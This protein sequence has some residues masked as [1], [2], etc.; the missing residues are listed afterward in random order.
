VAA[1]VAVSVVCSM[2]PQ[3]AAHAVTVAGVRSDTRWIMQSAD[4]DA[5]ATNPSKQEILPYEGNY[6]AWGLAM[7]ARVTGDLTRA[8][9][10][11]HWLYWF[12]SHMNPSFDYAV[13][14]Y[15]KQGDGT[16]AP[17]PAGNGTDPCDTDSTDGTAGVFMNAV[18]AAWLVD[19]QR[20]MPKLMGLHDAIAHA[21]ETIDATMS[22]NGLTQATPSWPVDYLMDNAE[23]Y[24]GLRAAAKLARALGDDAL[25]QHASYDAQKERHG[26]NTVLWNPANRSYDWAK[27]L[28]HN[29]ESVPCRWNVLYP[30]AVEEAWAVAYGVPPNRDTRQHL[31]DMFWNPGNHGDWKDPGAMDWYFDAAACPGTTCRQPV[32]YWPLVGIAF[33]RAGNTREAATGAQHIHDY[34]IGHGR[35]KPLSVGSAGMLVRLEL[36]TMP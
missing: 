10:A 1:A 11:W 24:G 2:L 27:H 32:G 21:V 19:R 31:M 3:T 9:V 13:C 29:K 4:G 17:E 15:A 14:Q 30:D 12:A 33:S 5:I 20:Y 8:R 26:M 18:H 23:A 22:P 36:L 7:Y 34:E 6:A 28:D 35:A 16:W 25:Q